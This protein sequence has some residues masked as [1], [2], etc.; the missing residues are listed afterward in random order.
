MQDDYT[1]FRGNLQKPQREILDKIYKRN[2]DECNKATK[3]QITIDH[4]HT[5]I[6]NICA[7]AFS[8]SGPLASTGY[9]YITVE[10][11][12]KYRGEKGNKIFDLVLYNKEQKRAILIECKS[13]I[14]RSR[15][16]L[17]DLQ[18]QIDNTIRHK[19]ELEE[20]IGG[21]INDMEYVICGPGQD[22]EEIGKILDKETVCLWTVDLYQFTIKLFNTSVSLNGS[23]TGKLIQKRQLHRD[24]NLRKRLYD[25]IESRG[26]IDGLQIT[27]SSHVCR[28]ISRVFARV[29]QEVLFKSTEQEKRFWLHELREVVRKELSTLDTDSICRISEMIYKMGI[30]LKLIDANTSLPKNGDDIAFNLKIGAKSAKTIEMN[31]QEK[32]IEDECEEKTPAKSIEDYTDYVKSSEGSLDNIFSKIVE[33]QSKLD[34]K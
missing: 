34:Q 12:Y 20:E 13:S 10:P 27:P 8:E 5:I 18:D 3:N 2:L 7:Y 24:E 28:V 16:I 15:D 31:I 25:K 32:Y 1:K 9:H 17:N 30:K 33:N 22:I 6:L 19:S 4:Q 11:L 14:G 26:Q 21:E 29:A 23:E